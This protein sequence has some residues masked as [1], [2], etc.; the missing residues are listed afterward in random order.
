MTETWH[1]YFPDPRTAPDPGQGWL[2][3]CTAEA[4]L[5]TDRAA[6]RENPTVL[7]GLPAYAGPAMVVCGEHDIFGTAAEVVR[8]RLPRAA[9]VTLHGSGHLHWLQGGP[10]YREALRHFFAT[11]CEAIT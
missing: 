11:H 3:G 7:S 2:A 4:M 5:R 9:Q 8:T 10:G 1:N 6:S